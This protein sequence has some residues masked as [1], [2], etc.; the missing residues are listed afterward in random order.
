[1]LQPL[2]DRSPVRRRVSLVYRLPAQAAL[3]RKTSLLADWTIATPAVI[4]VMM[5]QDTRRGAL[6][7][8]YLKQGY[9]GVILHLDLEW[10]AYGWLR[11]PYDP[12]PPHLPQG[13]G[14]E[15]AQ[16]IFNCRTR[17]PFRNRGLYKETLYLLAGLAWETP[18]A[19]PLYIDT[20]PANVPSRRAIHSVGFEPSGVLTNW[21]V[22]L[23]GIRWC[24]W[25]FYQPQRPHPRL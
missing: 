16:W 18:G 9:T 10:A 21:I 24:R 3:I 22:R 11:R 1:M 20:H 7:L 5:A 13:Y 4:Q 23:P 15:S 25:A 6:M 12:P 14:P 2:I 17:E 19:A 8:H